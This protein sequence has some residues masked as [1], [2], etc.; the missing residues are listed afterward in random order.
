MLLEQVV[1]QFR[2]K[3]LDKINLFKIDNKKVIDKKKCLSYFIFVQG[4]SPEMKIKYGGC[5]R[6]AQL[7]ERLPYKERVRSSS[8]L[9]PTIISAIWNR[10]VADNVPTFFKDWKL[11]NQKEVIK[12]SF[13]IAW[14]KKSIRQKIIAIF[15]IYIHS[16][17]KRC[18]FLINMLTH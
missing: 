2:K 7:V 5:G 18:K 12:T 16:L 15:I 13:F 6:L 4:G 3:L 17:K 10:K 8:L 14:I 11:N 1:W 9:T